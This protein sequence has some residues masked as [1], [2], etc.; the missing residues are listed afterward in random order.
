M[1]ATSTFTAGSVISLTGSN[2]MDLAVMKSLKALKNSLFIYLDVHLDDIVKRLGEMK[3]DRIVN[4][5]ACCGPLNEEENSGIST[6][7]RD[8]V[9]RRAIYYDPWFDVRIWPKEG[10]TLDEVEQNVLSRLDEILMAYCDTFTST[11]C[12]I[13][14]GNSPKRRYFY[15]I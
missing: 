7:I 6:P 4:F 13:P 2:P 10:A 8:I 1:Q 11:R 9:S 15:P 14:P 5:T 12:N 3:V